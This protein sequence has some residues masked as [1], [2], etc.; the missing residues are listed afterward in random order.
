MRLVC[1]L[2]L[3]CSLMA[4]NKPRKVFLEITPVS[5]APIHAIKSAGISG[6]TLIACGG[7]RYNRGDIFYSYDGGISWFAQKGIAEKA[8]YDI[9][10]FNDTLIY[11]VGYD[12]KLLISETF[13]SSW[14]LR[15]LDYIPLR[16]IKRINDKLFICGGDGFRRGILYQ[17]NLNGDILQ[18][19]TFENELSDIVLASDHTIKV[20]GFG[21]VLSSN[22]KGKTWT[23][24]DASGDFFINFVE[25]NDALFLVG[26]SGM[27]LMYTKNGWDK[28]IP[29][30]TSI[31]N[32]RFL[33]GSTYSPQRDIWVCCGKQGDLFDVQSNRLLRLNNDDKT[34]WNYNGCCSK[35]DYFIFC[36]DEGYI[37][38][39]PAY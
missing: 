16:R 17:C 11:A 14:H 31:N 3:L 32:K 5:D 21:I 30:K 27:I 10:P 13:G 25:T 22:D 6:D 26:R 24:E 4:C 29:A 9:V 7:F 8:I 35:D 34:I 38:K 2:Y 1:F 39:L 37:V 12:G 23:P 18:R 33:T 20:C 15:Q 19:D 36:T 28:M